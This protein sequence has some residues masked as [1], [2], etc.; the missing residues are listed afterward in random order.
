MDQLSVSETLLTF[1]GQTAEP[2]GSKRPSGI[3]DQAEY[4]TGNL[5][6]LVEAPIFTH[7]PQAQ[8]SVKITHPGLT[9]EHGYEEGA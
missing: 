2:A 1:S 3:P 4:L 7:D 6:H 9:I 5:H 8:N